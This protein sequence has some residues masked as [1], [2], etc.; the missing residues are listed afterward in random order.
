VRPEFTD[1]NQPLSR[2]LAIALGFLLLGA[3]MSENDRI[4]R[5]MSFGIGEPKRMEDMQYRIVRRE[6]WQM[7]VE[8]LR[9]KPIA[10]TESPR[11]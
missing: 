10:M 11:A 1:C 7:I 6:P 3:T 8:E 4:R 5:E 2:S 9:D